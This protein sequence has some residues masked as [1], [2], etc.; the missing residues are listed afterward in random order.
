MSHS[1]IAIGN[2]YLNLDNFS[3]A[4]TITSELAAGE[5]VKIWT[6]G[7]NKPIL[8][9]GKEA[10]ELLNA[11]EAFSIPVPRRNSAVL[12]EEYRPNRVLG[13]PTHAKTKNSNRTLG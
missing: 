5:V 1:I 11:L 13:E 4:E 7:D 8:F 10:D 2:K 12:L 9:T 3:Y 6:T